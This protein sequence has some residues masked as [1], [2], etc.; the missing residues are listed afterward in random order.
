VQVRGI[1]FY[2][3]LKIAGPAK[4]QAGNSLKIVAIRQMSIH[5]SSYGRVFFMVEAIALDASR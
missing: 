2:L 4:P 5:L 1:R 3:I